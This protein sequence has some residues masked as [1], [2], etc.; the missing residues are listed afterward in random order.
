MPRGRA[1]WLFSRVAPRVGDSACCFNLSSDPCKP[2]VD[3]DDVSKPRRLASSECF[4][5]VFARCPVMD[6]EELFD[7]TDPPTTGAERVRQESRKQFTLNES[8]N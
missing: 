8:C 4:G 1:V 5:E 2:L 6:S 3:P 7:I